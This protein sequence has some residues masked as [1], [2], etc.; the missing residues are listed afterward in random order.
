MVRI[1]FLIQVLP[2]SFNTGARIRQDYVLRHLS[3]VHE[4]TLA[5]SVR[6]DGGPELV[7][8]LQTFRSP[9]RETRFPAVDQMD[10]LY[11]LQSGNM[12]IPGA[13]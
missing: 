1:L 13:R 3:R 5:S 2:Y 10:D 12:T 11:R 6:S 8:R 4:V 7:A 9:K